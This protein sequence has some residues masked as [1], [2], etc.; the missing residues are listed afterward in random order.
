MFFF[1]ILLTPK[2]NWCL[3]NTRSPKSV[4]LDVIVTG[5]GDLPIHASHWM[6]LDLSD[7]QRSEVLKRLYRLPLDFLEVCWIFQSPFFQFGMMNWMYNYR[8]VFLEELSLPPPKHIQTCLESNAAAEGC[9]FYWRVWRLWFLGHLP[10]C[11]WCCFPPIP[12]LL[13]YGFQ[14]Q[15]ENSDWIIWVIN[16]KSIC[17]DTVLM[18]QACKSWYWK[19]WW[20][21]II[22]IRQYVCTVITW[23][24]EYQQS[25]HPMH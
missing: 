6:H 23:I 11:Q 7:F 13:T 9:C 1:L 21:R 5:W 24:S 3:L 4:R 12:A 15:P 16:T 8:F 17:N 25:K 14:L 18:D 2:A 19:L 20:W 22:T 10:I